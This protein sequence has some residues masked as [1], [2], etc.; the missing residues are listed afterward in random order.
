MSYGFT[1][2]LLETAAVLASLDPTT[3][4][5]PVVVNPAATTTKPTPKPISTSPLSTPQLTPSQNKK[6]KTTP[7]G[8][9][10]GGVIG[11]VLFLALIALLTW[12]LLRRNRTPN[13]ATSTPPPMY[14][15]H[16]APP[17]CYCYCGGET[18]SG[19]LDYRVLSTACVAAATERGRREGKAGRN[20][21][22]TP[23]GV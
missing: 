4:S 14:P 18:R 20:D 2:N 6:K 9:I 17:P 3:T 8:P 11:G 16:A 15:E 21:L 19:K 13:P 12:Y 1:V 23:G 7:I 22:Y 10:V 5:T